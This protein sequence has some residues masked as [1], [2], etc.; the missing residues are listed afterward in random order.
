[1]V[2]RSDGP[3]STTSGTDVGRLHRFATTAW[4]K[5]TTRAGGQVLPGDRTAPLDRNQAGRSI[6]HAA[7]LPRQ[8]T[9]SR[10]GGWPEAGLAPD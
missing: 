1:M 7:A 4:M 6:G 10:P 8:A 5:A 9:W 3:P 2:P